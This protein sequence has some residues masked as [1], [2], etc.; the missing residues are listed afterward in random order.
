[1]EAGAA[2]VASNAALLGNFT[3]DLLLFDDNGSFKDVLARVKKTSVDIAI[4]VPSSPVA[5]AVHKTFAAFDIPLVG[6]NCASGLLSSQEL[7]VRYG[8]SY[9]YLGPLAGA[10]ANSINLTKVGAITSQDYLTIQNSLN[11]PV[12][13]VENCGN[14]TVTDTLI[15]Y[16][17]SSELDRLYTAGCR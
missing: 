13:H 15:E 16:A 12:F 6:I 7:F 17:L 10:I 8:Y 5:V 1:M 2:I 9:D 14:V 11:S 4:G 3:F